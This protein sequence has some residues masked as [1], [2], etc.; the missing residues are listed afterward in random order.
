MSTDKQAPAAMEKGMMEKKGTPEEEAAKKK[1][2]EEE[3][4][5]KMQMPGK[6]G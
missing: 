1:K 3:K 4:K 6:S 2:E 5:M